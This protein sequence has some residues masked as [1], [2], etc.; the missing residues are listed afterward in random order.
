MMMNQYLSLLGKNTVL[1]NKYLASRHL[2]FSLSS[3]VV[4]G[5]HASLYRG[6]MVVDGWDTGHLEVEKNILFGNIS[7]TIQHFFLII[8]GSH[9]IILKHLLEFSEL[10]KSKN[11]PIQKFRTIF[12]KK[13]YGL[14]KTCF[15]EIARKPLNIFS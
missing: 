4:R 13:K 3:R 5:V 7:R 14:K 2:A 8:S 1:K 12:F 9:R 6:W 10:E 15:S 11:F